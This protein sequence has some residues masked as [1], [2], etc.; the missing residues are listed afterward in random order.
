MVLKI[1]KQ[2]QF[3]TFKF[4][5]VYIFLISTGWHPITA[6]FYPYT[7]HLTYYNNGTHTTFNQNPLTVVRSSL[8]HIGQMWFMT[9]LVLQR[10]SIRPI[11]IKKVGFNSID[12]TLTE[13]RKRR[14][15]RP[16]AQV[17]LFKVIL[18]RHHK[19]QN[20]NMVLVYLGLNW[21]IPP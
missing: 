21:Q 18:P 1:N 12:K 13:K 5:V 11:Y 7:L 6:I 17:K 14:K 16:F 19:I 9:G 4:S 10:V 3:Y 2:L 20:I 8:T 15:R